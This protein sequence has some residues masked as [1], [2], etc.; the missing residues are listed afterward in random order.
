MRV[1]IW[2]IGP[3]PNA[4]PIRKNPLIFDASETCAIGAFPFANMRSTPSNIHKLVSTHCIA[5]S[6][7]VLSAILLPH[8]SLAQ[9]N[10]WLPSNGPYA[11]SAYYLAVDSKGGVVAGN[12]G[13][14]FRSTDVG[15]TWTQIMKVQYPE[16]LWSMTINVNDHIFFGA[17]TGHVFRSEDA[18]GTWQTMQVTTTQDI[19]AILSNST[20]LFAAG[21]NTNGVGGSIFTSQDEGLTWKENTLGAGESISSFIV[22]NGSVVAAHITAAGTSDLMI[23]SDNGQSWSEFGG[24][25]N[26]VIEFLGADGSGDLYAATSTSVFQFDRNSK[27]W[28]AP[29]FVTDRIGSLT[30]LADGEVFVNHGGAGGTMSHSKG[31]ALWEAFGPAG[32]T[33]ISAIYDGSTLM[34]GTTDDGV[35]MS[36]NGG[37]TWTHGTIGLPQ[38][39]AWVY[40]ETSEMIFVASFQQGR[41]YVSANDGTSWS[42]IP[43]LANAQITKFKTT[44]RKSLI[45]Y[46]ELSNVFWISKDDGATWKRDTASS[47]NSDFFLVGNNGESYEWGD[48]LSF[49]RNSAD[50]GATWVQ[51]NFPRATN[52]PNVQ[53]VTKDSHLFVTSFAQTRFAPNPLNRSTDLGVTWT[54]ITPT[55]GGDS[56][57]FTPLAE[58]VAGAIYAVAVPPR[59]PTNSLYRSSDEGTSW[60]ALGLNLQHSITGVTVSGDTIFVLTD[61]QD[62]Q[63]FVSM[64]NGTTWQLGSSGLLT[65]YIHDLEVSHSGVSFAA[66]DGG[67]D[68]HPGFE[69]AGISKTKEN[70]DVLSIYPNPSQF[71]ATIEVQLQHAE[72]LNVELLD[73][74]GRTVRSVFVGEAESGTHQYYV[75][76]SGLPIGFYFCRVKTGIA[77]QSLP[78]IHLQ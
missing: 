55:V 65:G 25:M 74:L 49:F 77:T 41:S 58:G 6:T 22:A 3:I 78:M 48:G 52:Y 33:P 29:L 68:R 12:V 57:S 43:G 1:D 35:Y 16:V 59:S 32:T 44:S 60:S 72:N 70:I 31:S 46:N 11:G 19:I 9:G 67:I 53:L 71:E 4:H 28:S 62:S 39:C 23:S 36:Q 37:T 38:S 51:V 75:R 61:A 27:M 10:F 7:M 64:D 45:A 5:L 17:T 76:T 42:L 26:D 13:G 50:D 54:D 73:A 30:V 2:H 47:D 34:L 40:P 18:G 14:A 8:M 24:A 63:V 69:N 66:T 56:L 15:S 20:S 21:E